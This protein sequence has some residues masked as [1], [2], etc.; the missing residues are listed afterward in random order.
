VTG[1]RTTVAFTYSVQ[2]KEVKGVDSGSRWDVFLLK[3]NPERHHY[4]L[5]NGAIVVLLV[6]GIIA[7]ILLKT[8]QKD[9]SAAN[10]EDKDFKVTSKMQFAYMPW[11]NKYIFRFMMMRMILLVGD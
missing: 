10:Q 8:I 7:V 6:F 9:N 11:A 5:L 3:P 2:W 1:R 4:A